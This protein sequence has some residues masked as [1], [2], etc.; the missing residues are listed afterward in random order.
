[1]SDESF[2]AEMAAE[3]DAAP[4]PEPEAPA[5][6][7]EPVAAAPEPAPAPEPQR[8]QI[9]MIPQARLHAER[10]RFQA[11]LAAVRA[12]V[13]ALKTATAPKPIPPP[14]PNTQ[15]IEYIN[16]VEEQRQAQTAEQETKA[17][18]E[19]RERQETEHR[20]QVV[21]YY[22]EAADEARDAVP[23]FDDAYAALTKWGDAQLKAQGYRNPMQ[24]A[25]M[26]HKHEFDLVSS[27]IQQGL[28]P[29]EVIYRKAYEHGY[30]GR[31]QAAPQQEVAALSLGH[32]S[33]PTPPP[34]TAPMPP[35]N[36]ATGQFQPV[37]V[38][39]PPKAPR[40]LSQVP[41][42]PGGQVTAEALMAMT[43]KDFDKMFADGDGWRKLHGR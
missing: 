33:V 38:T 43:G 27:A 34:T 19:A 29:A 8:P 6:A 3:I 5:P 21:N 22:A 4:A 10:Q 2:V 25:Q 30:Q 28:N 37:A 16:W 7:P 11:E 1:M 9:D 36:P 23:D 17:Q 13:A 32:S 40:S 20:E 12:E 15:P 35:R 31:Q 24:R 18:T 42:T 26:L 14:D 41:G 39:P